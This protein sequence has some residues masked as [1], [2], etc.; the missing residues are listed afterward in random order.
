MKV[1]WSLMLI[2]IQKN[3]II[4]NYKKQKIFV[5]VKKVKKQESYFYKNLKIW[6]MIE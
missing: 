3:R 5:K 1:Q 2:I 4:S 6:L